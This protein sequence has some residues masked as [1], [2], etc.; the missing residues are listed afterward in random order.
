MRMVHRLSAAIAAASLLALSA[1]A[2]ATPTHA[3]RRV[4][5]IIGNGAYKNATRLPNP[6]NDAQDVAASLKRT[7]FDTIVGLDLDQAGMQD[8]AIKFARAAREADVAIFYYSGHAMQ[9]NGV[10]YL[11]P[12]DAKLTDEADL[13]RMARVDDIVADLQRARNLKIL[14]L[15]SCRDNPL[16]DQLKR[17][18]GRTRGA[19]IQRGL[20]KIESPQGT[21]V[22]YATQAG[23]TADDG[24]GRNSPY[25]K[26]FLKHIEERAEIGAIFRRISAD[27]YHQTK[28]GQLPELSLSLIGEFYLKGQPIPGTPPQ[29]TISAD[30]V[31]WSAIKDST[32]AALFEEFVRKFPASPRAAEARAR[33]AALNRSHI[34]AVSPQSTPPRQRPPQP[35]TPQADVPAADPRCAR[36][37]AHWE[38]MQKIATIAAYENHLNYFRGCQYTI[39]ALAKINELRGGSASPPPVA[40]A[41]PSPAPA[42][43]DPCARAQGHWNAMQSIGTK[44]AYENHLRYFGSCTYAGEARAKIGELSRLAV[45]APAARP[46]LPPPIAVKP[47]IVQ[48]AVL[49]EEDKG[50]P[51]GRRFVGTVIWRNET[52]S[53]GPGH[54]P[55]K[56]VRADIE[57]PERQIA[58]R[59]SL[60]RNDDKAMPASHLVEIMFTLPAGL[61]QGGIKNVP[62]ILMKEKEQARGAPLAGLAVK[63]T[64]GFFL[65]G[66]S[67][68]QA[69]V[70]KNL[71]LI[72]Q[73]AWIDIPV[74][75]DDG[76]RAI[77]AIEKG[78]GGERVFADALAAWRQ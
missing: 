41:E 16:S 1:L 62:G 23:S 63:V 58:M 68:V 15:D 53:S 45:A 76:T 38:S 48:R 25:T 75:Y 5:L 7:G 18:I 52:V 9:F 24:D 40:K 26:A 12:V 20:A 33:I 4:A 50:N 61:A 36:A 43:E 44:A 74:V 54:P 21:I 56:A 22:A 60:R 67:A 66:L 19:S 2:A 42:A 73:R 57:I 51:N 64:K 77:I 69:D 10:N 35:A 31:F 71:Q 39:A 28:R 3:E 11:M 29:A 34:A 6:K 70:Q 46:P 27:V 17:S 8:I 30:E 37:Q 32:I 59:L 65:I 72:R 55:E 47:E 13:R 49:Y 78:T 14:V